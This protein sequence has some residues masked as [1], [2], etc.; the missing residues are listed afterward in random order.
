MCARWTRTAFLRLQKDI[1]QT[2][3]NRG[4][5]LLVLLD[6][7]LHLTLLIMKKRVRALVAYHGIRGDPLK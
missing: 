3:D 2:A 5:A 1:F 6:P 4:G 7:A